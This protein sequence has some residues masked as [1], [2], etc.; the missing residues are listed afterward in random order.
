MSSNPGNSQLYIQLDMLISP[1]VIYVNDVIHCILFDNYKNDRPN[2]CAVVGCRVGYANG[3][4]K[5]LFYF[6]KSTSLQENGLTF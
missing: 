6:P 5:P 3:P 1:P 2:K 4:R